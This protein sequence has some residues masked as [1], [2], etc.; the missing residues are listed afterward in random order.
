MSANHHNDV[1]NIEM[2]NSNS[3]N[4]SSKGKKAAFL[5]KNVKQKS[6][7]YGDKYKD[8]ISKLGAFLSIKNKLIRAFLA[9]L[10]G[11]FL[12]LSI[13][14]GSVAQFVF[15]IGEITFV[16]M[17]ISFGFGLMAAIVVCGK[18]TGG[19]FNPAVSFAFLLTARLSV[20]RFFVYSIAQNLGAFLASI[21]VYLAYLNE[22]EHFPA[23]QFSIQTSAVFGTLPRNVTSS[24]S[25]ET[26][27]LFFDQF[28]ASSIFITVILAVCDENN[29]PAKLPHVIKALFIGFA[30]MIIGTA[31]G[32]N[33]GFAVNPA[34]DFGPRM[35]T[36]IFGWGSQVFEAGP[37]FFWI[38]L[39][40][41]M[42]GSAFAVATY[43]LFIGNHLEHVDNFE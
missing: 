3:S 29:T 14:L 33:C 34:R 28:F 31:Y 15:G 27:S 7:K 11:T 26:F 20:L 35:F 41:P 5:P 16:S 6:Q 32:I 23:G 38:P 8:A 2:N 9:E 37:Y 25:T 42:I 40:A 1:E 12:F 18:V 39:L 4:N 13:A 21:M 10:F 43:N 17:A 36:L 24:G 19:H 22:F 30:L